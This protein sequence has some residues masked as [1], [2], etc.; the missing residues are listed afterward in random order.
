MDISNWQ[1]DDF[2][3]HWIKTEDIISI[4]KYEFDLKD[5]ELPTPT[6]CEIMREVL[7][8][9]TKRLLLLMPTRYG[10]SHAMGML[11]NLYIIFNQDKKV[12]IIAPQ[13]S[14]TYIIRK[15]AAKFLQRSRTL[16]TIAHFS[17]TK[18]EGTGTTEASKKRQTF[19][20]GCELN[21]LGVAGKGEGAMGEGGDLNIVDEMALID[22]VVYRERVHRL[23]GDDPANS[24]MIGLANPWGS[25]NIA[26]DFSTNPRWKV[27]HV[28]WKQAILDGRLTQDFADEQRELLTDMEWEVLYEAKFPKNSNDTIL[29]P[30]QVSATFKREHTIRGNP[31]IEIGVDVARF[32][33]DSTV[34]CCRRAMEVFHMESHNKEDTMQTT[35]RIGDLIDDFTRQGF[36]VIINVDDTG[37]GGGVT[38]RLKEVW[39]EDDVEINAIINN[40]VASNERYKNKITEL[41]FW[42]AENIELLK[43]PE[44]NRIVSDFSKRKYK[45]SSN[46]KQLQLESKDDMKKR[47]LKSP[48]FADA[49]ANA[50]ATE[51]GVGIQDELGVYVN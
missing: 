28:D 1:P 15:V 31:P 34:I 3:R 40:A 27:M 22:P 26:K 45:I 32:G 18:E 43:F 11:V 49:I 5:N 19:K 35:G 6:Q 29:T 42:I 44:D 12:N 21:T 25:D 24:I 36:Q 38:D 47:G 39:E 41:W 51:T 2:W 30:E 13:W 7:F 4:C 46:G 20:N 14:Q 37:L 23:L 48:D 10:K 8:R 17:T 33:K 50:F 16:K 9:G